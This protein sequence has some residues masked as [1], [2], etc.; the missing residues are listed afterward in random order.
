MR[1]EIRHDRQGS[2]EVG[3]TDK[4]SEE[5]QEPKEERGRKGGTRKR[6]VDIKRGRHTRQSGSMSSC[7]EGGVSLQCKHVMTSNSVLMSLHGE[8]KNKL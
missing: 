1:L 6:E 5:E 3:Y 8:D 4:E 2:R 7:L